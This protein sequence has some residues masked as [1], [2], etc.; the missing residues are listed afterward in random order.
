MNL[1]QRDPSSRCFYWPI[2][3]GG[4]ESPEVPCTEGNLGDALGWTKAGLRVGLDECSGRAL[5]NYYDDFRKLDLFV[6]E[7]AQ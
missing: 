1:A 7:L 2:R 4:K 3:N 5:V 6:A